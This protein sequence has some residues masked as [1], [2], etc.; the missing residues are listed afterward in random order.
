MPQ[1]IPILNN[2]LKT[3]LLFGQNNNKVSNNYLL[4]ILKKS[5]LK[6]FYSKKSKG[7]N[8]IINQKGLNISGGEI[9]RIGIARALLYNPEILIMDE[10]TSALD[11]L[12]E[13]KILD[14]IQKLKKTVIIVSHRLNTFKKCDLIFNLNDDGVLK[15]FKKMK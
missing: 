3:N 14:E 10:S 6:K 7:L 1:D 15:K 12:T 9:Q 11:T 4:K 2:T 8:Q 13:N 5:N